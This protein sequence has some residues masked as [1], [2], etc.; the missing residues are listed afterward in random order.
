MAQCEPRGVK[1]MLKTIR[2]TRY[3]RNNTVQAEMSTI[4]AISQDRSKPDGVAQDGANEA[5][6]HRRGKRERC[7]GRFGAIM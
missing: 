4:A 6:K 3:E 2:Q 1:L 5:T 7:L